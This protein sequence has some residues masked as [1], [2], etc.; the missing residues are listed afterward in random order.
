MKNSYYLLLLIVCGSL[1][2]GCET[3]PLTPA[4]IVLKAPE[5]V[6]PMNDTTDAS[7]DISLRWKPVEHATSY[8]IEVSTREDFAELL[9]TLNTG[10]LVFAPRGLRGSTKYYWHVRALTDTKAGPWSETRTFTTTGAHAGL[11]PGNSFT[12]ED[13][14]GDR[15]MLT[16][17]ETALHKEGYPAVAYEISSTDGK[18]TLEIG[19]DDNGDVILFVFPT[20][21]LPFGSQAGETGVFDTI[22]ASSSVVQL[23][24]RSTRFDGA[25]TLSAKGQTFDVVGASVVTETKDIDQLTQVVDEGTYIVTYWYSPK[26]GIFVEFESINVDNQGIRSSVTKLID[27]DID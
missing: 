14:D 7:R 11:R 15:T 1:L 16:V 18:D 10:V 5:L 24:R 3:D 19:Y 17:I 27:F 6:S 26:L 23:E 9:D 12:F 8:K 21:V 13:E 2:Q 4:E 25:R 20:T 22:Y